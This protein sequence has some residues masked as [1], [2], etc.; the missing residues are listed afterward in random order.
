[1]YTVNHHKYDSCAFQDSCVVLTQRHCSQWHWFS[2]MLTADEVPN[3][4]TSVKK[5]N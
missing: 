2:K 3:K 4:T 5:L 1:M